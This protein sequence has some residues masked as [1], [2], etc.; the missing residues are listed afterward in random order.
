MA[1]KYLALDIGNV[2]LSIHPERCFEMLCIAPDDPRLS[3]LIGIE[4]DQL[5][6]GKIS[7]K[8]FLESVRTLFGFREFSDDYIKESFSSIIGSPLPGMPEL[9][10]EM[11]QL[12]I[13]PVFFS[14]TSALHMVTVRKNLPCAEII[15]DGVF[16]YECGARKNKDA[17][18]EIFEKRFGKPFL[19][20]DDRM[21]L[22]ERAKAR[23]WRAELFS[24]AA[25]LRQLLTDG[26]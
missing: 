15:R 12:G 2:C 7:D 19:Y 11:P 26:E 24:G 23:N 9:I 3:E 13:T 22:I 21:E 4:S 6:C 18:F 1:K 20:V 10:C 16:S 17:M 25:S 14:D 5:E 8:E